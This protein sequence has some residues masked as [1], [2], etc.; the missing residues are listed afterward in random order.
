MTSRRRSNSLPGE[1]QQEARQEDA[2]GGG[3]AGRRLS[4]GEAVLSREDSSKRSPTLPF[5]KGSS[6]SSSKVE[7]MSR[8]GSSCSRTSMT[9]LPDE[10]PPPGSSA[11]PVAASQRPSSGHGRSG[12]LRLPDEPTACSPALAAVTALAD[13]VSPV[14]SA[15]RSTLQTR[16]PSLSRLPE[17]PSDLFVQKV[18]SQRP[19]SAPN[20]PSPGGPTRR[21]SS[22][23]TSSS[24]KPDMRER[25]NKNLSVSTNLDSKFSGKAQ[26]F[27]LMKQ[28]ETIKDYYNFTEEIYSGGAKGKVL[29]ARRRGDNTEVIVKVRMKKANRGAERAWR[30]I[31]THVHQMR[32][33]RHVLD[34]TEIIEDDSAFYVV[35]PKCNGGELFEFLVTETE[36]PEAECKRIIREILI[37]IGHLHRGGLVH[38]DVKP[39]NIMF[40]VE[41][42]V[43]AESP[44]TVKLIDFD[45]CVEWTPQSPKSSRFVGT[46]GYIAPEALLGQ[47][48]PQSDI[49]SVGVI[50]YIL[51]TGETPW[52]SLVS[53]EDGT[54]GG[55]GAKRMY[56]AIKAEILEWDKEPWPDFP[57]ARDLCQ[58]L[59]A[60]D[61]QDR[62]MSVQEVLNHPW[63]TETEDV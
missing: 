13:P 30:A 24:K 46:P 63:L 38:R 54:V 2:G 11:S 44:K 17:D 50:L 3:G 56:D 55:P 36:V 59:M 48:T 62:P 14:A 43:S 15:E 40:N 20:A 28:G 5:L 12:I 60:F 42:A 26:F 7:S 57:Q 49:W 25:F 37:A 1:C 33:S 10:P 23:T 47:I 6:T 32:G 27:R 21:P 29:V 9:R 41:S 52:T 31:M 39:E 22:T 58:K 51:M 61:T 8:P 18:A 45:T 4:G 35:M 53:L 34:I 16:R 19:P